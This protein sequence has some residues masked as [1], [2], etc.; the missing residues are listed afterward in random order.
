MKLKKSDIKIP[1]FRVTSEF[2]EDMREAYKASLK[3]AGMIQKPIVRVIKTDGQGEHIFELVDG[4][5][6]ISPL[7]D[8]SEIEVDV[9]EVDDATALFYNV[10]TATVKGKAN[11]RQIHEA[12]EKIAKMKPDM[13]LKEI[14][15]S[16]GIPYKKLQY[17]AEPLKWTPKMREAIY[18]DKLPVQYIRKIAQSSAK[19]PTKDKILQQAI[20]GAWRM[21]QVDAAL[22]HPKA[23][24]KMEPPKKFRA[25]D[26][27]TC[28][29]CGAVL[30]RKGLAFVYLC[31][32][33]KEELK[34]HVD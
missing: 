31:S 14:A 33:C 2:D 6:R 7:P 21:E 27:S 12:I 4:L 29:C 11:K 23:F 9:I 32:K 20:D 26:T 13:D 18:E 28:Q 17:L 22:I 10:I 34:P 16:L 5:N 1:A 3:H 24:S 15:E 25:M 19:D 8:D 30:P